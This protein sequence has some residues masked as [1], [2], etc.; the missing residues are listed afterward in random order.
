[1]ELT[2]RAIL[3]ELE[4]KIFAPAAVE[5]GIRQAIETVALVGSR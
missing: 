3:D 1:M 5:E 4:H 2:D